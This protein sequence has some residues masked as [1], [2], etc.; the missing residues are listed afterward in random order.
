MRY[1]NLQYVNNVILT[2][3]KLF[4]K[5]IMTIYGNQSNQ[6]KIKIPRRMAG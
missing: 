2:I 3:D 4:N 6:R 1:K 5:S